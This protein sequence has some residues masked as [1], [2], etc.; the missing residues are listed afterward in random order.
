MNKHFL[1]FTFFLLISLTLPP[2]ATAQVIDI[3]DPNLRAAIENALG[4][5]VGAPITVDQMA[6]LT[7]LE[8]R[9]A[10]ISNLTG[11]ESATNLTSLD[12]GYEKVAN[13]WR[14]SNAVEDLSPV[15]DLTQL[16]RLHLPGNS[17]SDISAVAG[18]TNLTWLNLWANSVLNISAVA[19]LTNLKRT[20][21]ISCILGTTTFRISHPW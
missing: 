7:R 3:P 16:T 12:L 1:R 15:A 19:G 8:A 18:L 9:N 11:L 5:S 6:A 4:K 17:I 14:N 20:T 10:N 2:P 13:E 21:D